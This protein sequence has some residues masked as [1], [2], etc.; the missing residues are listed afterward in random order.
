M[1]LVLVLIGSW[2]I[3]AV[4]GQGPSDGHPWDLANFLLVSSHSI[5]SRGKGGS[6]PLTSAHLVERHNSDHPNVV[7]SFGGLNLNNL[8]RGITWFWENLHVS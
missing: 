3:L 8:C 4:G 5:K 2:V 6:H 7:S 1:V